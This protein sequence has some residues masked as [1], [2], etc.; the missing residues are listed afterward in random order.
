M[1]TD[2]LEYLLGQYGI[3]LRWNEVK[4]R[5]EIK[6]DVDLGSPENR[7]NALDAHI[8]DLVAANYLPTANLGKCMLAIANR[9]AFNP[10]RD[11]IDSKPW[12]GIHRIKDLCDTITPA[13]GYEAVMIPI[14]LTRWLMSVVAAA[15]MP[16]FRTRGVLTLQGRQG[17]GKTTWIKN[18]I[19]EP[20][21]AECVKLGLHLD[22]SNKDS[23]FS[24]ISHGIVELGELDSSL[25]RDVGRL[26]GFLTQEVDKIRMPYAARESAFVRRTVF[27][28][29]VNEADFLMDPTGNN[30]FWTIEVESLN[31]DHGIDMQQ[32]FAELAVKV[33]AGTQWWLTLEEE[34]MLAVVNSRHQS[35]SRIRDLIIERVDFNVTEG[36]NV[37]PM[38]TTQ[39]LQD[40]GIA[41]PTNAQCKEATAILRQM[42]GK[43]RRINGY[44]KWNLCLR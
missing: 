29:S 25:K 26:K 36:P 13:E 37:S 16:N 14:L 17:I 31:Y 43:S 22:V 7:D 34:E 2:N 30:R 15:I 12:D 23:V 3:T 44:E 35:S 28:A 20:A 5:L 8:T 21:L 24:A 33:R 40:L 9:N 1:T 39:M 6:G 42:K 18:L 32:V 4:R 10:I 19:T 38:S 27:A 41:H 11:W